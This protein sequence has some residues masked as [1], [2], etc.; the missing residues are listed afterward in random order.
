MRQNLSYHL[1]YGR[2]ITIVIKDA[3]EDYSTFKQDNGIGLNLKSV[4]IESVRIVIITEV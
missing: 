4:D 1:S 3:V 2:S